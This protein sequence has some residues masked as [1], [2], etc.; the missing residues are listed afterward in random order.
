MTYVKAGDD[1]NYF[2]FLVISNPD[3]SLFAALMARC[4]GDTDMHISLSALVAS[5]STARRMNQGEP[6]EAYAFTTPVTAMPR[7]QQTLRVSMTSGQ[8]CTRSL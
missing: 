5:A 6:E 7:R 8:D 1:E 4:S 2:S 3:L